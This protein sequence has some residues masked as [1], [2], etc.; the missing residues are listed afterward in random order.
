MTSPK[1]ITVHEYLCFI[2]K[3]GNAKEKEQVLRSI[4]GQLLLERG[5][6]KLSEK[7]D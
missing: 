6:V 2:L 3:N 1:L 7:Q 4:K 5:S